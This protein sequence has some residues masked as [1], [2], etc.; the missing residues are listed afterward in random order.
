MVARSGVVFPASMAD[1]LAHPMEICFFSFT[2]TS[3]MLAAATSL[4]ASVK[5]PATPQ[6]IGCPLA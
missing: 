5:A 6:G 3:T 1:I 2:T 4:T